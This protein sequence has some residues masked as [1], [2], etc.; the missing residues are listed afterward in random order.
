MKPTPTQYIL[1]AIGLLGIAVI[2]TTS[3]AYAPSGSSAPVPEIGTSEEYGNDFLPFLSPFGFGFYY[4]PNLKVITNDSSGTT[5]YILSPTNKKSDDARAIV[6]S[7]AANDKKLTAEQ[8]LLSSQ[9]GFDQKEKYFKETIDDQ[10]VV[11]T[12]GGM[13][14]IFNTPDNK[15]RVSVTDV[16]NN[17]GDHLYSAMGIIYE[18][19]QFDPRLKTL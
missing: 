8:W 11:R 5:R 19:L 3:S 14:F 6:I 7:V 12:N 4:P 10:I 2:V 16:P 18:S 1:A 17:S 9:S 15:Y 13:W